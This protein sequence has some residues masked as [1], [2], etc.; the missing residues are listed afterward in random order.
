MADLS[1]EDN[2]ADIVDDDMTNEYMSKFDAVEESHRILSVL[3]KSLDNQ[4][5]QDSRLAVTI[6][7][8]TEQQKLNEITLGLLISMNNM[9]APKDI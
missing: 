4:P 9:F 3:V 5:N 7:Y 1:H 6:K 8:I 2:I